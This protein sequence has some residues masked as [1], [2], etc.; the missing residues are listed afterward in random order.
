MGSVLGFVTV[1]YWDIMIICLRISNGCVF[2]EKS[3]VDTFFPWINSAVSIHGFPV[4][5]SSFLLSNAGRVILLLSN[6]TSS[7][8]CGS[9]PVHLV[10]SWDIMGNVQSDFL[11]CWAVPYKL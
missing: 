4:F 9:T 6:R 3:T 5:L 1:I 7:V 10:E 11:I 8:L 2:L